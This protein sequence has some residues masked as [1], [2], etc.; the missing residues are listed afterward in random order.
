MRGHDHL[1]RRDK[2]MAWERVKR[3]RR[4]EAGSD[5]WWMSSSY[6]ARQRHIV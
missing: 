6:N 5:E 1:T 4:N 2:A 3:A